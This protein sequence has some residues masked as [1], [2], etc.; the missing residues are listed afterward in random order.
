[1]SG[2]RGDDGTFGWRSAWCS[3]RSLS[4]AAFL[5]LAVP[6]KTGCALS[7]NDVSNKG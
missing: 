4:C 7:N 2:W 5:G 1:M 3:V 6:M